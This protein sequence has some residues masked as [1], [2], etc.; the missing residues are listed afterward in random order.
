MAEQHIDSPDDLSDADQ[1]LLASIRKTLWGYEPPRGTRP[2]LNIEVRDGR[3]R[4]AGRMRTLAMKEISEYLL[5]R[6][7][8]VRGV[9]NEVI[10]DP[11]IVRAVADVLATDEQ[12][13]PACIRVDSRDGRV[14]LSGSVP[15]EALIQRAVELASG[16]PLLTDVESRLVV[17]SEAQTRSSSDGAGSASVPPAPEG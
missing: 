13:G 12:L 17:A 15:D 2:S 5:L 6:S 16:V 8:G 3:V 10:T 1:E 9:R 7:K 11:E 4:L 14:I